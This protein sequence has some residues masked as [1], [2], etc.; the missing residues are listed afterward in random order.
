MT[1]L[2]LFAAGSATSLAG[3]RGVAIDPVRILAALA[4]AL[5]VAW[6]AALLLARLKRGKGVEGLFTRSAGPARLKVRETRRVG[7][8]AEISL[9]EW[10]GRQYLVGV[11]GGAMTVLDRR[12]EAAG[13]GEQD[14]GRETG[15]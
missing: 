8:N 13:T 15:I 12:E 5:I 9:V 6:L 14:T 2:L 7:M 1:L 10:D 4:A 3:G 11:T